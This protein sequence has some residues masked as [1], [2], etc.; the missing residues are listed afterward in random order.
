LSFDRCIYPHQFLDL[1]DLAKAFP[2]TRMVLNHLCMPAAVLGGMSAAGAYWET[3]R[4]HRA[5]ER[6]GGA[7]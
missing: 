1:A 2:D 3:G 6:G 4:Y 7:I 5:V